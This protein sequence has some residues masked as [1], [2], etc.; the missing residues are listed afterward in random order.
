MSKYYEICYL[1]EYEHTSV[2]SVSESN[3]NSALNSLF[4][5]CPQAIILSV[6]EVNYES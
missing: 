1:D 4:E 3:E 6:N 2:Y 5:V